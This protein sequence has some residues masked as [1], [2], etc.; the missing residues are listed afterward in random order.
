MDD[1]PDYEMAAN[2]PSNA[3]NDVAENISST[4]GNPAENTSSSSVDDANAIIK[5]E[6]ADNE[7]EQHD[8]KRMNVEP[9]PV[10]LPPK[11]QSASMPSPETRIRTLL[12]VIGDVADDHVLL[13]SN[14]QIQQQ[15]LAFTQALQKDIRDGYSHF[16]SESLI[17]AIQTYPQKTEVY[18]TLFSSLHFSDN[19]QHET[20]SDS[21]KEPESICR[22]ILNG[23]FKTMIESFTDRLN[24][25]RIKLI[26]RFLCVCV[27]LN[28]VCKKSFFN[29]V[30]DLMKKQDHAL[31]YFVVSA[32]PWIMSI[33][34]DEQ[35]D[36]KT[37]VENMQSELKNYKSTSGMTSSNYNRI[38]MGVE[39]ALSYQ[40]ESENRDYIQRR[41]P[42]LSLIETFKS[43]AENISALDISLS[44]DE[45]PDIQRLCYLKRVHLPFSIL[46]VFQDNNNHLEDKMEGED[47][48]KSTS[49]NLESY[50]NPR[51]FTI[52]E[53]VIEYIELYAPS[54]REVGQILERL[55]MAHNETIL[56]KIVL[57]E[58]L[59][60]FLAA[61]QSL[62]GPVYY[63]RILSYL[64]GSSSLA[65]TFPP[66]VDEVLDNS[67]SIFYE[68]PDYF[69]RISKWIAYH[70]HFIGI[71]NWLWEAW[72]VLDK[73][74]KKSFLI[75]RVLEFLDQLSYPETLQ[76]EIPAGIAIPIAPLPS[77]AY[78]PELGAEFSAH[79]ERAKLLFDLIK[80]RPDPNDLLN[81]LRLD[82]IILKSFTYQEK[83]DL[84]THCVIRAGR[85]S[86][87]HLLTSFERNCCLLIELGCNENEENKFALLNSISGYWDSKNLPS[88]SSQ[89]QIYQLFC[90]PTELSC[91]LSKLVE[92]NIMDYYDVTKWLLHQ[93]R[94]GLD[95]LMIN[96]TPSPNLWCSQDWFWR[97]LCED[98]FG[99][100]FARVEQIKFLLG[101]ITVGAE[102]EILDKELK[103][104]LDIGKKMFNVIDSC[105]D[106]F[107]NRSPHKKWQ[108]VINRIYR[109][110][111]E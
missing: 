106:T 13:K 82:E 94:I 97:V 34:D 89:R 88:I 18:A 45:F 54:W 20:E 64:S 51:W 1:V 83:L 29:F 32:Y 15:I 67:E 4:G 105:L 55:L 33:V 57:E 95:T 92:L 30:L 8:S 78:F 61:P 9:A 104:H 56:A 70:I 22:L 65:E 87:S 60:C 6:N 102:N 43:K 10:K 77:T 36:T 42:Y 46:I 28:S 84:V 72:A 62:H 98:I 66:L 68:D 24:F 23:L 25:F 111:T 53:M 3:N 93:E 96:E 16:I 39:Y 52:R 107:P 108:V 69:N 90:S 59:S 19:N 44:S 7:N 5:N 99:K 17:L 40:K 41:E 58:L 81:F 75:H 91:I 14:E 31:M 50:K 38:Q 37:F 109:P 76:D 100:H 73:T 79:Q 86:V 47:Q 80:S 35:E 71:E 27:K 11:P 85:A 2:V 12:C 74:T 49:S 48:Q 110:L 26:F 63:E 103:M 21:M 101:K